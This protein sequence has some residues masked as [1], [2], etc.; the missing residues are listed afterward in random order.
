VITGLGCVTPVG[1]DLE[2][3]W[4]ALLAGK[5]GA[6]EITLFDTRDFG[7]HF[8]N[9]VKDYNPDSFM[10]PKEAKRA[11]RFVHMAM[12]AAKMAMHHA[13]LK[14]GL[15]Q[16]ERA[17]VVFASGIGGIRSIEEQFE[18]YLRKGPKRI[19]AFTIPYLM[20]N[21]APGYIAIDL[22]MK[23]PNYST[24]TAC[25][26][27]THAI[28]LAMRH[29]QLHE[30]DL[31]I[32]GGSEAGISI[33]GLGAFTNMGALSTRN[34]SPTTASRPFDRERDGFVMGE[35]SG[36][37]VLEA[38]EHAQARKARILAEV[39]GYGFTDDAY[40]ITSPDE[41]GVGPA[42]AFSQAI[43]ASGLKPTDID[44]MN[45]HGTSTIFNDR[46]E[47][48]ALQMV[49]GDH[50]S[51][52]AVSSTKGHTGHLL[53]AA[54]AIEAVFT[55]RAIETGMVPPTINFTTPDPECGGIDVTPNQPRRRE[56][57]YAMSNNLG[58][59]GHNATLCFGKFRG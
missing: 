10:E 29:I 34:D 42:R 16:P 59:G 9:E 56:I 17:G 4:D 13:G 53:G 18:R 43:A 52:M 24:V 47:A 15:Y 39:L 31:M 27:A 6:A 20:I 48:K 2:A 36:A 26:S 51:H 7:V 35:G 14:P 12:G 57:N 37:L 33:L 40:H 3:A 1:N 45:A 19:S 22:G 21:S 11:D 32:C 55:V 50:L 54:G 38:L 5:S 25:A 44:Y 46:T 58:F 8:A 28:G 23:G 49:F 41:T 30:A